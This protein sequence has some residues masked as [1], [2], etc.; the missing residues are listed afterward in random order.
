MARP[1]AR[2]E[3]PDPLPTSRWKAGP[4]TFGPAGRLVGTAVVV[5]GVVAL[6]GPYGWT[7]PIA[8][9]FVVAALAA[10]A[11]VLRSLW[12]KERIER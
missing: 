5:A 6:I 9:L 10:W 8:P 1:W 3:V 12:R 2:P 4:T 7:G 11:P